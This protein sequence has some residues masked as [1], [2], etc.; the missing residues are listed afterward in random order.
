M[1]VKTWQDIR[2]KKFSP[3]QLKEIDE[4]VERKLIEMDLRTEP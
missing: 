2:A 4:D 3:E 1:K